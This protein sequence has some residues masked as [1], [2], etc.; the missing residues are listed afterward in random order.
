MKLNVLALAL[1][2]SAAGI[3]AANAQTV[4]EERRDPAIVVEHDHPDASVT[5]EEHKALPS[6]EKKT[7]TKETYGSGDC[8]SKTVHKEDE[9]GSKTVQ[10]TNCD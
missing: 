3:I 8:T 5:V 1:A 9:A 10:K 4:I 7:I 6:T 2:A